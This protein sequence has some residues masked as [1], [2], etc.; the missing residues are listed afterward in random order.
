MNSK[1]RFFVIATVVLS[2]TLGAC[3]TAPSMDELIDD[4]QLNTT[5]STEGQGGGGGDD[6]PPSKS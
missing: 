1:N 4:T 3:S 6:L 2:M 5:G